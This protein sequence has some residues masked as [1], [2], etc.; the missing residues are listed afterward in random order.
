MTSLV[1]ITSLRLLLSDEQL[2]LL[3]LA[4][5]CNVQMVTVTLIFYGASVHVTDR[6]GRT[7][8]HY[9]MLSCNHDMVRTMVT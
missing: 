6:Y 8:L 2:S 5:E 9:A 7:L 3:H 1:V 4:M